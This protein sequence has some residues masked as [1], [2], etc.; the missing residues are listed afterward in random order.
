M[1]YAPLGKDAAPPAAAAVVAAQPV[2]AVAAPVA[3]PAAGA[4]LAA[5]APPAAMVQPGYAAAQP[6]YAVAQPG[7]AVAQP[8]AVAVPM[9]GGG[10]SV[11]AVQA[12][13]PFGDLFIKQRVELVRSRRGSRLTVP[14]AASH[15][16]YRSCF[17][18]RPTR[19]DRA[20]GGA[21]GL[22]DGE[23]VRYLWYCERANAAGPLCS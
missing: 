10:G 6:G 20:V 11:P 15:A 12:L 17:C 2:M 19:C 8:M 18:H 14:S 7:Y 9:S 3:M 4:N 23:S 5:S 22:R 21:H 1:S 16:L 13:A